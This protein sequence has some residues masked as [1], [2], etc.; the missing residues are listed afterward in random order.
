V[1]R[2]APAQ[3]PELADVCALLPKVTVATHGR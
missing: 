2:G 3:L 1:T